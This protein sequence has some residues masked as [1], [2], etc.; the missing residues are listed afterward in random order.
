MI[1]KLQVEEIMMLD[2]VLGSIIGR[3]IPVLKQEL[4]DAKDELNKVVTSTLKEKQDIVDKYIVRD[5]NGSGKLKE[6][7]DMT[8][9][10]MVTDFESSDEESMVNEINAITD[11]EVDINFTTVSKDK[12]LLVKVDGEYKTFTL[13][14]YLEMSTEIDS[15]ALGLLTEFFIND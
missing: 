15:R 2:Q 9:S 4:L 5:E 14:R 7:V 8:Q 12:E 3:G 11:K 1:K 13:Q 10:L 6:G